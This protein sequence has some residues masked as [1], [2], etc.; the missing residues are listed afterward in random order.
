MLGNIFMKWVK[1]LSL[2]FGI[3]CPNAATSFSG[4][5]CGGRKAKEHSCC[6]CAAAAE[7]SKRARLCTIR[8]ESRM[9]ALG[10]CVFHSLSLSF[11][12]LLAARTHIQLPTHKTAKTKRTTFAAW[13][14]GAENVL[15]TS[16]GPSLLS[17]AQRANLHADF[18]IFQHNFSILKYSYVVTL[19]CLFLAGGSLK[20]AGRISAVSIG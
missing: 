20:S 8:V 15:W 13:E 1:S 9:R 2:D 5:R 6:L 16:F 12:L 19:R 18:S 11:S 14:N 3:D 17:T 10:R 4:W 7:W